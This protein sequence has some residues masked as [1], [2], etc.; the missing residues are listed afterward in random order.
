[1]C[2]RDRRYT[3]LTRSFP[4]RAERLFEAAAKTAEDK[5]ARLVKLA[6]SWDAE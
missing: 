2:I 4:E 5:Y 1:M 6:K 3:A